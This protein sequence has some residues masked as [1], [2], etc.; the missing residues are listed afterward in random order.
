MDNIRDNTSAQA[1]AKRGD[2]PN[3]TSWTWHIE[4]Y[5][6]AEVPSSRRL[7]RMLFTLIR[8]FTAPGASYSA[9]AES[10]DI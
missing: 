9:D 6:P 5:T 8:R 3:R 2:T 1:L 7:R 4:E 10:V